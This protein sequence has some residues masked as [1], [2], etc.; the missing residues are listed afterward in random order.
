MLLL[1]GDLR[2][3]LS[4]KRSPLLVLKA[5]Q[6]HNPIP[7]NLPMPRDERA[8]LL[9]H[10]QWHI[11]HWS[12]SLQYLTRRRCTEKDYDWKRQSFVVRSSI[13]GHMFSIIFTEIWTCVTSS[14]SERKLTT[15]TSAA[16]NAVTPGS[17][18]RGTVVAAAGC[19][20]LFILK[21]NTGHAANS[22]VL[23]LT[24]ET[25]S[26]TL[27]SMFVSCVRLYPL[28]TF[29]HCYTITAQQWTTILH[30]IWKTVWK[31]CMHDS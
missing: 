30:S 24:Y 7:A 6:F 2:T 23:V 12:D 5:R 28:A 16:L 29:H 20:P 14:A 21:S 18:I 26:L 27:V 1:L 13:L 4:V 19:V 22:Y 8:V 25:S 15:C 10:I 17:R 31:H 9:Q 3:P 11:S